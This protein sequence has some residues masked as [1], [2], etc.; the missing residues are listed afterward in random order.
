LAQTITES[1]SMNRATFND[2]D[3]DNNALLDAKF[4][5]RHHRFPD[6]RQVSHAGT[7]ASAA[8]EITLAACDFV[9]TSQR[10]S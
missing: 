3:P 10:G 9:P 5:G 8:D 4:A 1:A 2:H 6:E 7:C